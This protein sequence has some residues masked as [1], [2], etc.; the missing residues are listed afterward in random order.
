MRRQDDAHTVLGDDRH[1]VLKEL[2]ARE[3]VEAR[4]R[5]VQHEQLRPLR[6]RE[7][8]GERARWPPDN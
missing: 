2:A 3:W 7:R 5:L 1:E 4:H 6:N 8:E